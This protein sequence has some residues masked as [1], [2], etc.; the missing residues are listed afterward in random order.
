MGLI[1]SLEL[2]HPDHPDAYPFDLAMIKQLS[3]L[4]LASSVTIFTGENGAGKST[5]LELIACKLKLP[6]I[7]ADSNYME[8]EFAAIQSA[9]P[10][11]TLSYVSKPQ[12]FF[13]R[14]EDFITYIRFLER[15]KAEAQA[16][17][18]RIDREYEHKSAFAKMM[19]KSP[20]GRTIG[21]IDG[22][23]AKTL[24]EESHGEA[25]LDFFASRLAPKRLYLLDEAEVPLSAQN[26]LSLLVLIHNA[27]KE[28]CQFILSTHSPILMAY[29]EATIYHVD[30][31]G[32]NQVDYAEL[33][34]V[35]L[36]RDFL[37]NKERYLSRLFQDRE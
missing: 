36:L 26:Q 6:R 4:S 19:A 15:E 33:P 35:A 12:G 13:F 34:S 5:L 14:A 32:V 17:L 31:S 28:G 30:S 37:N 24:S 1:Q 11:L 8:N 10:S 9:M 7:A 18:K 22:M 25:Y 2:H 29:P 20:H 21:E 16:E 27:V 23:Y 3:K